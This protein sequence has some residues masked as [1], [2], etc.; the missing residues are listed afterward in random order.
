MLATASTQRDDHS[1]KEP[2][3]LFEDS[4]IAGLLD[5]HK[6]RVV[7]VYFCAVRRPKLVSRSLCADAQYN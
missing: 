6:T 4:H 7:T 5:F 1:L 3:Y 2:Q